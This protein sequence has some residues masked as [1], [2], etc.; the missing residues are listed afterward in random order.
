MS[1]LTHLTLLAAVLVP[2]SAAPASNARREATRLANDAK[3]TKALANL[4]PGAPVPCISLAT[5]MSSSLYGGTILYRNS[6]RLTY[7]ND[8]RGIC[9]S[10]DDILVTR[11]WG[12][13][14]CRGDVVRT[15]DR[16]SG[17]HTGSCVLGDFVPY[18]RA[19]VAR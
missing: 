12:S 1:R 2:L 5:P 13:Q 7:R 6:G 16:L 14:L 10:R 4:T 3:I 8:T 19:K 11:S 17:F 9:G 15:V 18:R